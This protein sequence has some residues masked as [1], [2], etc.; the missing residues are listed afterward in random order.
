MLLKN[1]LAIDYAEKFAY[2]GSHTDTFKIYKLNAESGEYV[3][4]YI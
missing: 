3:T 1:S 4:G 2:F